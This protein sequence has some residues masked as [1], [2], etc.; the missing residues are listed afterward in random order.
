ML[1]DFR[2]R[3]LLLLL[4]VTGLIISSSAPN[5]KGERPISAAEQ[6]WVDSVMNTLT[7]D[8]RL[9]QLFMVAAYSNK[10]KKHVQHIDDLVR[11]YNIGGV[12]FLQ[13]GPRR[14]AALTNRYQAE[15]K[16]PLLVALDAEWG[17][18][19]RLDSSMHFAKEMTL[20][21]IEDVRRAG[22][23]LPRYRRQLQSRQPGYWQPLFWR[24]QGTGF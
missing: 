18:D 16:V 11:N 12:M 24:E 7:P 1:K 17:L 15:A 6:N 3:L 8:Q 20:G 21:A 5:D 4:A 10:D 23:L 13:G 2:I 9:G 19:M 14:Q 22:E